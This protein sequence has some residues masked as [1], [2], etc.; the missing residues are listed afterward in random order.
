MG[1]LLNR[2]AIALAG[3]AVAIGVGVGIN[4]NNKKNNPVFA[5][6]SNYSATSLSAGK[7]VLIVSHDSSGHYYLLDAVTAATGAGPKYIKNSNSTFSISEGVIAGELDA[8]LF[9]VSAS[10]SNWIFKTSTNKYLSLSS[11]NS[12]TAVRINGTSFAWTAGSAAGGTLKHNSA[13]RYL[14]VYV[15]GTDWR[16][17]NSSGAANYKGTGTNIQFFEK[18]GAAPVIDSVEASVK[19]GTYYAGEKLSASDFSLT[20]NWTEG[21]EATHPTSDFTWKVNDVENG[22]LVAGDNAVVVTYGGQNSAAIN[23]SA[24]EPPLT[25]LIEKNENTKAA[26]AYSYYKDPKVVDTLDVAYTGITTNAYNSWSKAAPTSKAVYA[27]KSAKGNDAIQLNNPNDKKPGIVSTTSGGAASKISVVWNDNTA[28]GKELIIYGKNKAYENVSDL[29][30]NATWG[31]QIGTIKKGTSTELEFETS[32]RF[33]GIKS[34]GASYLDSISIEWIEYEYT[35]LGIRFGG[36]IS[37]TTWNQLD[38]EY[39]IQGYGVLLSTASFVD[40]D[41][42]KDYYDLADGDAVKNFDN[43]NTVH[44]P[45]LKETPTLKDGNYVWNLYKAVDI[46]DVSKEYVAVAYIKLANDQVVF[47]NEVRAKL[48]ELAKDLIDND[49]NY[50]ASSFGGSL[51]Y[52]ASL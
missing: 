47:L 46:S 50:D 16:S 33:I 52:L 3:V 26:P 43:T 30:N 36:C 35:N 41:K 2:I 8:H 32:Y 5:E 20:V 29:Y 12:N 7:Q 23:V 11:D 19:A 6:P 45:A 9:T 10:G 15:D 40:E 37:E 38:T 4:N 31:T 49:P 44:E 28:S 13:N 21:K 25:Y 39:D 24:I 27:G 22:D 48:N 34:D 17:Y 18:G 1:K 14:G 51:N 42:L